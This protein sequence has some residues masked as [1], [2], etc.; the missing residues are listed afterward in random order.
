MAAASNVLARE[1]EREIQREGETGAEDE[2]GGKEG[3]AAAV[4]GFQSSP[5]GKGCAESGLCPPAQS[6]TSEGTRV[7]CVIVNRQCIPLSPRSPHHNSP[8]HTPRRTTPITFT[9][10]SPVHT[11]KNKRIQL[12]TSGLV[13]NLFS[14]FNR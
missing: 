11:F 9:C 10:S 14:D 2:L 4:F 7:L 3:M 8:N 13:S 12:T 1:R 5:S 6:Q